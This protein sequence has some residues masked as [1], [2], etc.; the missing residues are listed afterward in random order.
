MRIALLVAMGSLATAGLCIAADVEASI[1]KPTN[2]PAEPLVPA[3]KTLAR[4]RGFQV[5]FRSEVVGTARTQGVSGD[6]TTTEALDRLLS[7]TGLTY[8]YLDEKTVTILPLATAPGDVPRAGLL[9]AD[10]NAAEGS[11]TNSDGRLR[12]SQTDQGTGAS[13][14][15]PGMPGAGPASNKGDV[16]LEEV[17]VTATKRAQLLSDVPIAVQAVTGE[18]LAMLGAQNFTD[19]A[20]TLAGVQF[21]DVGTGRDQIFIRGVAA[22]QGYIGMESAIGVY[23]D[24]VPI[25]EGSGQPDLNLYDI[26]RVEVLRGPQGT[27]YGSASLGGTIRIITNQ[28]K[29]NVVEGLID[30]EISD[31]EHGGFNPSYSATLNLPVIEDTVAVRGVLYGRNPSGF[32]DDPVLGRNAVNYED[33]YGGRISL[34]IQPV[35][36]LVIDLKVL[37]QHTRQGGYNEADNVNGSYVDLNQYRQVPEPFLDSTQV[38]NGTVQYQGGSVTLNSSTSFSRRSRGI[39]DDDTGLELFGNGAVTPSYQ[40]YLAESF[41][42]EFRASS[43]QVKPFS[44]LVG[45]YFNRTNDNFFQ[46]VDSAGAA[47]AFALPSDNVALLY[48]TSNTKQK[49]LFGEVGYSPIDPLTMTLGIRVADLSLYSNSLRTG[50]LFGGSLNGADETSQR[51]VAPKANVSLKLTPAALVYAQAAKGYR[52][53][54]VNVTIEPTGDGFVFP[55]TYAPDSL[56]NY[57]LGFKGSALDRHL[58]FDTDVFY[59][60][61]KNIQLDLQHDGYD[62][63]ANAGNAVSKGVEAQGALQVTRNLELG[64][65]ATYT[66]ARLTTTTPGAGNSGDRVPYVPQL[67]ASAFVTLSTD[68]APGHLY[69]RLD[70]QHVG[71]AY[72]GFGEADNFSYGGYTL[73]NIKVG[74]DTTPWRFA[75]FAR[76]LFDQRATLFARAYAAGVITSPAVDAVTVVRPRTIGVQVSRSF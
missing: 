58:T 68:I 41:T 15:P 54:G 70:V 75:V 2:I 6:L 32:I 52:I 35:Q 8:R 29:M 37:E 3:L 45:A 9:P 28:P 19:Y 59:I 43:V 11:G 30:T 39:Y 38:Y 63:F 47:E 72:T 51:P 7:G 26:D 64:G 46:S 74:L 76:N 14:I 44:W 34:R 1:R 31:T 18:E 50:Y 36:Q 12:L 33:T 60:N 17:V 25:S 13:A 62:Y 21:M 27:L 73:T 57:E 69:G 56:W 10:P 53:G 23:L 71:T 22:P 42:Q 48:Q 16:Q 4:E 55:K 49:A 24:D 65:Q 61:W 5:V 20:R 40:R 67:A 66:D